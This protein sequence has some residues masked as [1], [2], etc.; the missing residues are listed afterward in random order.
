MI[1]ILTILLLII[2]YLLFIIFSNFYKTKFE[3]IENYPPYVI[4]LMSGQSRTSPFSSIIKNRKDKIL[5]SY[6]DFTFNNE[7]NYK[8]FIYTDDMNIDDIN[9]F[10]GK[11][12]IGNIYLENKNFLYNNAYSYQIEKNFKNINKIKRKATYHDQ[13]LKRLKCYHMYLNSEYYNKNNIVI[14]LR[15]DCCIKCNKI[16]Y[17]I[18]YYIKSLYT[19]KKFLYIKNDS[20]FIGQHN[21]IS[22]II[23]NSLKFKNE[24]KKINVKLI[25][26]LNI[27]TLHGWQILEDYNRWIHS[28][29]YN[30]IFLIYKFLNSYNFNKIDTMKDVNDIIVRNDRSDSIVY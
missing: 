1:V 27:K 14:I 6:N 30:I 3:N 18:N 29:E 22:Y 16:N 13:Y 5:K 9:L 2:I 11:D 24:E 23:L 12:N 21:I 4:Y 15:P 25:K 28:P 7:Y 17:N 20:F 19:N 10:F 8:L 26:N